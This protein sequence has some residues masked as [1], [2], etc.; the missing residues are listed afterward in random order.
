MQ[1]RQIMVDL[2]MH[3]INRPQLLLANAEEKFDANLKLKDE[4]SRETL[5]KLL[6]GLVDWTQKLQANLGGW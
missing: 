2:N 1:L 6:V 5:R 4:R 3:P